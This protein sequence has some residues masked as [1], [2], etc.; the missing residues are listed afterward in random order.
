VYHSHSPYSSFGVLLGPESGEFIAT[1]VGHHGGFAR[2][3]AGWADLTVLICVLEGLDHAEDLIDVAADGEI[4]DAH[5]TEDTLTIDD[6]GGT[7][8]NASIFRGLE[9]AAVVASDGLLDIR[10]HGNVH[11]A[12]TTCLSGLHCV[13]SVGEL[14]VD[15]AA[16]DLAVDGFKLSRLVAELA[17]LSWADESEVKGPEEK[18]DIF[19]SELF[20][21]DLLKFV[22]PP[23]HGGELGSSLTNDSLLSL[24]S[25]LNHV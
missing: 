24:T 17:N 15:G 18:H 9:K 5:L 25:G 21:G 14:R 23:C 7:K 11:G 10:D 2:L 13:F 3:P 20:K 22:L 4:V 6:V 16:N 19:A 12:K 8:S 1:V